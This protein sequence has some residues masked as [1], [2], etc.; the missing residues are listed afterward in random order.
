MA[1][2]TEVVPEAVREFGKSTFDQMERLSDSLNTDVQPVMSANLGAS[3]MAEARVAAANYAEVAQSAVMFTQDVTHGLLALTY[4]SATVAQ[5]YEQG[6]TSQQA[7]MASVQ[8]SFAPPPGAVTISSEQ[9][10]QQAAA[11]HEEARL[12]QLARRMGEDLTPEPTWAD[13]PTPIST[14]AAT[15]SPS[16]YTEAYDRVQQHKRDLTEANGQDPDELQDSE[17]VGQESYDPKAEYEDLVETAEDLNEQGPVV[18]E[19]EVD[20]YGNSDLVVSP[21]SPTEYPTALG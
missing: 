19:V 20:R 10:A 16:A 21:D 11:E 13:G 17:P 5:N 14:A 6:D 7:Q 4:T 18:W 12:A 3:G 2:G 9:A 8:N 1:D 15:G